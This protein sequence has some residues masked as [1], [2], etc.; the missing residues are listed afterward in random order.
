VVVRLEGPARLGVIGL[1]LLLIVSPLPAVTPVL[2][3][4][5]TLDEFEKGKPDGVAVGASG[6]LALAPGLHPL[7]LPPLEESAEPFLWSEA[8]DAKGTLYLG[9]GNGGAIYRVPPG[10]AGSLYFQTGDLAVHALA[11]DKS[12]TLY[13]GSSPQGKIYRITGEA[14]GE[15]YFQPEDRYIWALQVGSKGELY[16]ATGERGIIY[17][18]TSK[19]KGEKFFD[20]EEFHITSLAFDAAGNLLAGSDG[21]GLLYR[22]DPQG[23]A[24]VLY[25][26][27]LREINAIAV[28]PKGV[29]YASAIGM[30]SDAGVPPLRPQQALPAVREPIPPGVPKSPEVPIPGIESG[31]TATVTVTASATGTGQPA[32]VLLPRSEV[33][34]ID[35]DGTTTVVWSSQ[36]ETVYSLLLDAAGRP[37]LG[38]GEP[39][40]IRAVT[41]PRQSSLLARLSESQVTGMATGPGQKLFIATSNVG[42]AYMLDAAGAES[43]SYLS[44][45]RDA[46]TV[47]RWG[48]ISWRA[49]LPAGAKVELATR[50]GNS[51]LPD[52]TWSDWSPAYA[53]PEG[54]SVTSP[55]ARFLQWRARLARQ[56]T[57]PGPTL[58]AVSVAYLQANLPPSL[59][60]LAIEPPGVIRE[61]LPYV[62][63]PDPADLAFTGIRVDAGGE[64]LDPSGSSIPEKKVFVRGMR[65]V[66]WEAE[67]SND[68]TLAYDLWFRGEGET[69]W[70]PLARRLGES[71]FAFD[72]MQLPDGLYRVR[73]DASD[74]PSNPAS[75]AKTATLTSEAFLV[76]NTPPAVQL[77]ARKGSRGAAVVIEAT[78]NDTMGPVTA[79][80]YSVDAARWTKLAPQDGVSDSRSESYTLSLDGLK[81]G[82]HTVILKASDLLGNV[83]AGKVTFTSE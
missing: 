9:A 47:A 39:G 78:A 70:K 12:E 68:D 69:S 41:G 66:D 32:A 60:M 64:R 36:T 23:K 3:T 67:D 62:P 79:A 31:P 26:S 53:S 21:K 27:A 63:E 28:D 76:D 30:E 59:R 10:S 71:Y 56:G 14:K 49:S 18:I 54:S 51:S 29:V 43:G 82:E 75:D 61:R 74:A 11:L 80:E 22:I 35:P 55:P 17:K 57:G 58:Y 40:R 33:Y 73:I 77:A 15:V 44:A 2:W 65:A 20:S 16:A 37:I 38:T 24:T 34:R 5:G 7:K 42:K 1:F 13:A 4:V 72:S 83:G 6:D 45:P 19:G 48:R 52:A 81:P 46:Q 8:V 50:S 25:D